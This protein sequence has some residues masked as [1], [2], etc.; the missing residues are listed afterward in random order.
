MPRFG[1]LIIFLSISLCSNAYSRTIT[2]MAGRKVVI[3][4]RIEKAVALSPPATYMLYTIAP[5]FWPGSIFRSRAMKKYTR[6]NVSKKSRS[7]AA[8]WVKG[9][10]STLRFC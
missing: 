2:D 6:L 5:R 9:E 7:S 3:P 8:W 10:A 4:D 1:L